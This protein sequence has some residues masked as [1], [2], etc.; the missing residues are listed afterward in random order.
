MAAIQVG[1]LNTGPQFMDFNTPMDYLRMD[2]G[3]WNLVIRV[4]RFSDSIS[5]HHTRKTGLKLDW[6]SFPTLIT[7]CQQQSPLWLGVVHY[8]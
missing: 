4:R 1:E 3:H 8:G 6:L 2:Y 5:G 7:K